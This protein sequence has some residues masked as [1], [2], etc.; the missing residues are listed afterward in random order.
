M[1]SKRFLILLMV[2]CF[3]VSGCETIKKTVKSADDWVK[4]HLW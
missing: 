1:K 3:T 4:E 2:L